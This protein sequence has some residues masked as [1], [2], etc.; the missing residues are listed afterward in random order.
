M[1][2]FCLIL[3]IGLFIVCPVL[4]FK[5]KDEIEK[6]NSDEHD[7]MTNYSNHT[8]CAGRIYNPDKMINKEQ[9]DSICVLLETY[10]D[11][12]VRIRQRADSLVTN[13]VFYESISAK[14]F[15]NICNNLTSTMCDNGFLLDLYIEDRVIIINP[16]GTAKKLVKDAYRNR[17][18][19]SIRHNLVTTEYVMSLIKAIKLL[20]YKLKGG[21]TLLNLPQSG[22][23]WKYTWTV[24]VP[25]LASLF[26]FL[27]VALYFFSNHVINTDLFNY[28]DKLLYYWEVIE[29]N[30]NKQITI[31]A[32]SCL[33]CIDE[34]ERVEDL[35]FGKKEDNHIEKLNI[36]KK[37]NKVYS[38]MYCNHGYHENC[39]YKW[40]LLEE[41]CC[42]CSFEPIEGEETGNPDRTEPPVLTIL[43]L[44]ILLGSILDAHKKESVYDYFVYN[45]KKIYQINEK[46][47][48]VLEEIC[49]LYQNKLTFYKSYYIFHKMWKA[50]KL[51]C[52]ILA[53]YP[54]NLMNSKKGR[55]VRRL[56]NIKAK[57][58]TIGGYK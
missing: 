48:V 47:D 19:E 29:T 26:I 13:N 33:F 45:E 40:N 58:A 17:V 12:I 10:Q 31:P 9:T 16:G 15:H 14:F 39:L 24:L 53:F 44:K 7:Y 22:E 37:D 52:F 21:V 35:K 50:A 28:M 43:D 20:D 51:M 1:I 8:D 42:P 54:N 46:Y 56:L 38:F 4:L 32:N 25:I 6:K 2:K 41:K 49:W 5:A 27:T 3:S 57:G 30:S 55:L 11:F 18:I 36:I 23:P 34:G